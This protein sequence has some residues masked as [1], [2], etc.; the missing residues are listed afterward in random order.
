MIKLAE[1]SSKQLWIDAEPGLAAEATI[2]SLAKYAYRLTANCE[3]VPRSQ[4][5]LPRGGSGRVRFK[6]DADGCSRA[7]DTR[8]GRDGF[9][10][11]GTVPTQGY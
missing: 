10:S 4:A 7:D 6:T 3:G 8:D 5:D 2:A 11:A 1:G 9:G